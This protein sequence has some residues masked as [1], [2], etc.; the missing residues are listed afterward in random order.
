[1]I[2]VSTGEQSPLFPLEKPNPLIKFVSD[3]FLLAKD[4]LGIFITSKGFP[5]RGNILWAHTPSAIG[6]GTII[7]KTRVTQCSRNTSLCCRIR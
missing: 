3:E 1:M 2:D 5:T 6:I 7:N 4:E